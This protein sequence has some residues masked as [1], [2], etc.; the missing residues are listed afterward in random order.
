MYG[1][2]VGWMVV[3]LYV[4]LYVVWLVGCMVGW[5]Y[6]RMFRCMLYGWLDV[7]LDA[8]LDGSGILRESIFHPH[9]V[10]S[11]LKL[12]VSGPVC[13]SLRCLLVHMSPERHLQL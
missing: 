4:W 5:M 1:W 2:I 13:W 8:W 10:T 9:L 7:W 3:W 6:G 11:G 12:E